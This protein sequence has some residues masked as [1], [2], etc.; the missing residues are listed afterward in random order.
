MYMVYAFVRVF[1]WVG[2]LYD[3]FFQ[4]VVLRWIGLTFFLCITIPFILIVIVLVAEPYPI[5]CHAIATV[6]LGTGWE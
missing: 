3:W 4:D 5:R 6:L 1:V 2:N